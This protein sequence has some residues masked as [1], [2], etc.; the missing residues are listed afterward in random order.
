MTRSQFFKRT[1][2]AVLV[3]VGLSKVAK[4]EPKISLEWENKRFGR[5][6]AM[7]RQ[8]PLTYKDCY[9]MSNDGIVFQKGIFSTSDP[10]IAEMLSSHPRCKKV[11]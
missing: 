11:R 9:R 1:L 7:Y 2:G 6:K 10:D 3:S 5:V 8:Y 4:A